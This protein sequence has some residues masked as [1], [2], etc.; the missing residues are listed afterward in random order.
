MK[1]TSAITSESL[2]ANLWDEL[3]NCFDPEIPV[4]IVD[5]GLIY[6][7]ETTNFSKDG[8]DVKITMTLTA[9]GCS[10]GQLIINDVKN[11]ASA[12]SG[13]KNVTIDLV[14]DPPWSTDKMSDYAKLELG[15]NS[16]SRDEEE[17]FKF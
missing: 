12:V 16:C 2:I 11:R 1:K 14:F 9:P 10:M 15:V 7:I 17:E 5:L 4:N 13:V 3:R 6:Q 8:Y